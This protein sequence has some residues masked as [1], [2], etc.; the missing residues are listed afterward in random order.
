MNTRQK[1]LEALKEVVDPELG[2][3]VVDLGLIYGVKVE[4]KKV[5]VKMTLTSPF[6]PLAGMIV[7]NVENAIKELGLE[8][9]IKLVFSPLWSPKRMS[10]K[11]RKVFKV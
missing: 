1:V 3:S 11:A 2:L 5:L 7:S 9:E 8:P 10:A 4:G 6:C